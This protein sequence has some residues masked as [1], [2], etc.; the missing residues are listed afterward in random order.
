MTKLTTNSRIPRL[1]AKD[2]FIFYLLK[3]YCIKRVMARK[4]LWLED[5][6]IMGQLEQTT[7]MSF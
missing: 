2:L 6:C 5:L 7:L 3:R 1:A 4:E